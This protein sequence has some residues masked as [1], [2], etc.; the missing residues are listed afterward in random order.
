MGCD[1]VVI[2]STLSQGGKTTVSWVKY[3][4]AGLDGFLVTLVQKGTPTTFEARATDTSLASNYTAL[5]GCTATVTPR[6][7]SGPSNDNASFAAPLPFPPTPVDPD[8]GRPIV[9]RACA[10]SANVTVNWVPSTLPDVLGNYVSVVQNSTSLTNFTVEGGT[11]AVTTV[12]YTVQGGSTYQVIVTPYDDFGPNYAA[13]S[14]PAPIPY[15]P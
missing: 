1:R 8:V 14:Y 10:D 3:E 15:P 11:V 4:M 13:A 5:A 6:T 2:T 9:L 12:E 7:A